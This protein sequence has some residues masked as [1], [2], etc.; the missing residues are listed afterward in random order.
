MPV[1]M[2]YCKF[3]LFHKKTLQLDLIDLNFATSL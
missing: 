1:K 3:P 2:L